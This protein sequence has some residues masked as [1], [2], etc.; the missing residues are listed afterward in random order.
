MKTVASIHHELVG[1]PDA[2]LNRISVIKPLPLRP[3]SH[4]D[5]ATE[6]MP[7][8]HP[9]VTVATTES[10]RFEFRAGQTTSFNQ[11]SIPTHGE[12][13]QT[14]IGHPAPALF[15]VGRVQIR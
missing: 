4:Q 2:F 9:L 7:T 5:E 6:V 12:F 15:G 14:Q 1:T 3:Q 11:R 10:R 8:L 13:V